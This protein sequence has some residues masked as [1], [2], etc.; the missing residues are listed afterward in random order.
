MMAHKIRLEIMFEVIWR[1]SERVS[2]SKN[3][4]V[5]LGKDSTNVVF[6]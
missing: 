4:W 3:R 1:K 6:E 5:E 2:Y